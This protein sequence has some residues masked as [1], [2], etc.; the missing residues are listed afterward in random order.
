MQRACSRQFPLL[1]AARSF[2][3]VHAQRCDKRP[4]PFVAVAVWPLRAAGCGAAVV[5]TGSAQPGSDPCSCVQRERAYQHPE[6]QGLA[7]RARQTF[8]G[9]C[10]GLPSSGLARVPHWNARTDAGDVQVSQGYNEALFLRNTGGKGHWRPGEQVHSIRTAR[11]VSEPCDSRRKGREP[12]DSRMAGARPGFGALVS[13]DTIILLV[14]FF[15]LCF[16]TATTSRMAACRS[17][18]CCRVEVLNAGEWGTVCDDSWDDTDASVVC[19]EVGC[20]GG[21][22]VQGFGG[23]SG[24]IWMD[25][26]ACSG[27]ESSL[28]ACSQSGWESHNCDHSEDAGACCTGINLETG[29]CPEFIISPSSAGWKT[30]VENAAPGTVFRFEA[31][32]YDECD[33]SLKSGTLHSHLF[34]V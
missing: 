10:P 22:G 16:A 28:T 17:D 33:I 21:T 32:V 34:R 2:C 23:G 20:S 7:F 26:V 14:L 8:C 24:K 1:G 3:P 25:D 12:C 19:A 31:G 15:D 30:R 4:P 18:G 29:S 27:S 9:M 5:Q 11:H 6:S 13:D